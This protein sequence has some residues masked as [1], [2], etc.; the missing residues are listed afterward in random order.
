MVTPRQ[1]KLANKIIDLHAEDCG[2]DIRAIAEASHYQVKNRDVM[3]EAVAS[4]AVK[5]IIDEPMTVAAARIGVGRGWKMSKLKRIIEAFIPEEGIIDMK[6]ADVALRALDI[7]N[8]LTGDYAPDKS[9][10]ISANANVDDDGE[11][12]ES[13]LRKLKDKY[14]KRF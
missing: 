9:V 3:T 13:I 10:S 6:E 2:E 12:V 7:I 5:D 11:L 8:K 4:Q 1:K 14:D